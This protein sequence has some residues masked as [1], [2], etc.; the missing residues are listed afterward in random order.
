MTPKTR[1]RFFF[2][3]NDGHKHKQN[4]SN[5]N[6]NESDKPKFRLR[7][8]R[9]PSPSSPR[10]SKHITPRV[11]ISHESPSPESIVRRSRSDFVERPRSEN[12]SNSLAIPKMNYA[13]QHSATS[14]GSLANSS[15]SPSDSPQSS[16]C[17]GQYVLPTPPVSGN[18][19]PKSYRKLY[20]SRQRP[21]GL[22]SGQYQPT[23]ERERWRQWDLLSAENADD[24]YEKETLV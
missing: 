16:E 24:S 10:S 8:E 1:R 13:R 4:R 18:S 6:D 11:K 3:P 17:S 15:P 21:L 5:N 9:S 22:L 23:W 14:Y 7:L 2:S 19:S 12:Y 20:S